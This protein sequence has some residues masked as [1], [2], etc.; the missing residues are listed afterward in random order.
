MCD[1]KRRYTLKMGMSSRKC[2]PSKLGC[3]IITVIENNSV[4][5]Y[6]PVHFFGHSYASCAD[7]DSNPQ[8]CERVGFVIGGFTRSA[9]D[10]CYLII[11]NYVFRYHIYLM[12]LIGQDFRA[13][14]A[15]QPI[16]NQ[17]SHVAQVGDNIRPLR[18]S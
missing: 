7:S 14:T 17:Y 18:L 6:N 15:S 2:Y 5:L 1:K 11:A 10:F 12:Q 3:V 13:K 9:T 16:R 4:H 8:P